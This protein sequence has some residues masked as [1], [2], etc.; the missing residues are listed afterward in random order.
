MSHRDFKSMTVVLN[1][2][3]LTLALKGLLDRVDWSSVRLREDCTWSPSLLAAAALLWAWGDETTLG[4]R[5]VS[6]RRLVVHLLV[7]AVPLADPLS[8]S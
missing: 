1:A 7:L 4:G 6:A 8:R 3:C 5:F 2:D